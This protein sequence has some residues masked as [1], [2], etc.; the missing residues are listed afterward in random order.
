MLI[1]MNG[2]LVSM[3]L[4]SLGGLFLYGLKGGLHLAPLPPPPMRGRVVIEIFGVIFL[5]IFIAGPILISLIFSFVL[6]QSFTDALRDPVVLN[7]SRVGVLLGVPFF[8]FIHG[9]TLRSE[10]VR[11]MIRGESP[12]TFQ[13]WIGDWGEA[14]LAWVFSMGC[15]AI[16]GLFLVFLLGFLG[17]LPEFKQM[18]VK[19]LLDVR[20][21]PYL[22]GF[23]I[24]SIVILAPLYEEWLFR[25]YLQSWLR[26]VIGARG[27]IVVTSVI[28]SAAHY[29]AEQGIGNVVLLGNL[30]VLSL[31]LGGIYE[32]RRS[33][34]SCILLH[35]FVNAGSL[36]GILSV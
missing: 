12:Y 1:E 33:L 34:A 21:S 4:L 17:P 24:F 32:K 13:R 25:G 18:A 22:F 20:S 26:R 29:A 2:F 14:A 16:T 19:H 30:F 15:M 11:G 6:N 7:A 28:F 35:S 36:V 10:E 3:L 31:F 9:L 27:G 5:W 8:L 23:T